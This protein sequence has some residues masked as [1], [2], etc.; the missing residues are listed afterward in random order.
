VQREIVEIVVAYGR[1][2]LESVSGSPPSVSTLSHILDDKFEPVHGKLDQILKSGT[3]AFEVITGI[4][5]KLDRQMSWLKGDL[6]VVTDTTSEL[7]KRSKPVRAKFPPEIHRLCILTIRLKHFDRCPFCTAFVIIR[8]TGEFFGEFHHWNRN[9]DDVRPVNCAPCC[10]DCHDRLDKDATFANGK[11]PAFEN[12]QINL[13]EITK[14]EAA[15]IKPF[16]PRSYNYR[17]SKKPS[18]RVDCENQTTFDD[19]L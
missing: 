9:R 16:E 7:L 2:Q 11:R 5:S 4:P 1:G 19:D 14:S 10:Q 18:K 17:R 8:A 13:A 12:F 15:K 3:A 6:K